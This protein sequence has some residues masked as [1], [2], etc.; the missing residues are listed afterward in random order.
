MSASNLK[1]I[2]TVI[3][4]VMIGSTTIDFIKIMSTSPRPM[5][6]S[7]KVITT[8]LALFAISLILDATTDLYVGYHQFLLDMIASYM[9]LFAIYMVL[10]VSYLRSSSLFTKLPQMRYIS[11]AL[12][13]NFIGIS[14]VVRLINTACDTASINGFPKPVDAFSRQVLRCLLNI[15]SSLC[16]LYFETY[17][18]HHIYQTVCQK[19][20]D[21]KI[22]TQTY[23]KILSTLIALT[24]ILQSIMQLLVFFVVGWSF[25]P[26]YA[27]AW[28]LL[29]KRIMEFKDDYVKVLSDAKEDS[30][31]KTSDQK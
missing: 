13:A 8:S 25:A 6:K 4:S 24:F 22:G 29:L 10:Y 3:R 31:V 5:S 19:R 27:L 1:L 28:S 11:I 12:S 14:L 17:T 20:N 21:K 15:S 2:T 26:F 30:S 16:V 18:T 23:G 9:Q 7:Y